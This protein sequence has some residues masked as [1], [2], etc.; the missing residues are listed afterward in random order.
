VTEYHGLGNGDGAVDVAECH[1]FLLFA[2]TED[3]VLLNGVQRLLLSLQLYDVGVWDHALGKEHLALLVQDKNF[4]L[5]GVDELELQTP[6]QHGAWRPNYYLFLDRR[7]TFVSSN[8]VDKFD[9]RV[10]LPH[11]R[12]TQTLGREKG[13]SY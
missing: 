2:I 10:V 1:E 12:Y 7:L 8:G 9:L 3:I 11:L 4:D 6:V 5:L 13:T